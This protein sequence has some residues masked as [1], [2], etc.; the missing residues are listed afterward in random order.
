MGSVGIRDPVTMISSRVAL[1]WALAIVGITTAPDNA[2]Q[3]AVVKALGL[4]IEDLPAGFP[5]VEFFMWILALFQKNEFFV[6]RFN[7]LSQYLNA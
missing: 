1:D 7:F 6:T 5:K 3:T 2:R 4:E